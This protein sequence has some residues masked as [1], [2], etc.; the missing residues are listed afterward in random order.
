MPEPAENRFDRDTCVVRTGSNT[1]EARIDPGWW[2]LAGPNGGY[3][4]AVLLRAL[5]QAVGDAE[6][7]PRSLTIHFTAPPAQGPAKIETHIERIGRSLTTVTARM[8]QQERLLCIGLAAFSKPRDGFAFDHTEA[9]RVP[10]PQQ[11]ARMEPAIAIHERYEQRWAGDA[12]PWGRGAEA[13]SGGWIRL[14]EP[15]ILDAALAA[16]YTDAFPPA[17]FS[18]VA[19]GAIGGPVPTV[20]LTVHFRETLPRPGA[21]ADE[22]TLALFRSR[23]AH[24]GFVEE[25]GELWSADGVLLAQSRQLAVVR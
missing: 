16:A 10:P 17:V 4:A 7:A 18:L 23:R 13:R 19:A 3:V 6:R 2:I 15:R 9:P 1:F 22:F 8:W 20:D 14:A 5:E 11:C 24:A 25:D 21:R 12:R